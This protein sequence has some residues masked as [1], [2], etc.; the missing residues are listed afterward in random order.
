[1]VSG[2]SVE[3]SLDHCGRDPWEDH[4]PDG[5][6]GVKPFFRCRAGP[7]VGAIIS[8]DKVITEFFPYVTLDRFRP[9]VIGE[10]LPRFHNLVVY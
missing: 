6:D 2:P 4:A 5:F 1:M 9:G 3:S 7:N 8:V 10:V